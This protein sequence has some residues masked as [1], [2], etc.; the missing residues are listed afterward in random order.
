MSKTKTVKGVG[1]D[2]SAIGTGQC[3]HFCWNRD[4]DIESA[5]GLESLQAM[6]GYLVVNEMKCNEI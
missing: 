6:F 2:V 5:L 3:C 1:W 4:M